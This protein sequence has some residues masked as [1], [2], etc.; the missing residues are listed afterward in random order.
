VSKI[1]ADLPAQVPDISERAFLQEVLKCYRHEAFRSCIVMTWNLAYA[2][3]LDWILNDPGRLA[4]FNT[5]ITKRYPKKTNISATK[6]DD[7]LE[8]LS[9]REVIEICNSGSL[10]NST[11]FRIMKEKLGRRNIA[12]HPSNVVVVQSQA[13][14]AITDLVNNVVLYL[15]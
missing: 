10:F 11:V 5:A 2:H 14:D 13:D 4:T 1:L 6:Y 8:E 7:F 3:L 12:A 9:E 15:T